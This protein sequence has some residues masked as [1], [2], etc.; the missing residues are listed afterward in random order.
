MEVTLH[1]FRHVEEDQAHRK[2]ADVVRQGMITE[3]GVGQAIDVAMLL[4][5]R[6]PDSKLTEVHFYTSLKRRTISTALAPYSQMRATYRNTV[7]HQPI[8]DPELD[9]PKGDR[10]LIK[11]LF[12]QFGR[13]GYLQ[14][15]T[16]GNLPLEAR[17]KIE[18][19]ADF[20]RRISK[21]TLARGSTLSKQPGKKEKHLVIVTHDGGTKVASGFGA[22]FSK[23][24]RRKLQKKKLV[25]MG[26]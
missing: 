6:I 24:T 1:L 21:K 20:N 11:R 13:E 25:T 19:P 4:K 8:E 3:K 16:Q 17:G 12:E 22:V 9:L 26:Q 10:E 7:L 15:W 23:L 2:I 18:S 5:K 14:K